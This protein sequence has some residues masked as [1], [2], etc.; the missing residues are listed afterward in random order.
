VPG[1]E[2]AVR[3]V[4]GLVVHDDHQALVDHTRDNL[5]S[6]WGPQLDRLEEY[7]A[8]LPAEQVLDGGIVPW[9]VLG[10]PGLHALLAAGNIMSTTVAGHHAAVEFPSYADLCSPGC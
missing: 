1:T 3:T 2:V 4:D 7:A 8:G 10:V 5:T 9:C 6:Y